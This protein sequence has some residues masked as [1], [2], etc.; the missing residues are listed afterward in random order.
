M[1]VFGQYRQ[2]WLEVRAFY[3]EIIQEGQGSELSTKNEAFSRLDT[4]MFFRYF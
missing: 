3:K 4:L 1:V 2:I